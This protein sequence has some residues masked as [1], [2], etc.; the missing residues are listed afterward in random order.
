MGSTYGSY[1]Y[2]DYSGGYNNGYYGYNQQ[3]GSVLG[4]NTSMSMNNSQIGSAPEL[5]Q[6]SPTSKITDGI[7]KT[8]NDG[9]QSAKKSGGIG[10]FFKG[11][12]NGIK[13][14]FKSLLDPKTW[15]MIAACVALCVLVPGAG[16]VLM[17][18][19]IGMAG[20]Q[21]F[22]GAQSGDMEQVGEGAFN[23]GLSFLGGSSSV[24]AGT[25]AEAANFSR[26]GT[27]VAEAESSLAAAQKAGDV[28]AV[29]SAQK[30]VELARAQM[31]KADSSAMSAA[32]R[33]AHLKNPNVSSLKTAEDFKAA[34]ASTQDSLMEAKAGL[35]EAQAALAAAE[36]TKNAAEIARAQAKLT[37]AET[38]AKQAS[39]NVH[40]V[41]LAE[42]LQAT[43]DMGMMGRSWEHVKGTGT[44]TKDS[45]SMLFGK[46]MTS[47]D[48]RT[49]SYWSRTP[50]TPE[51]TATNAEAAA[52]KTGSK[53]N[54]LNWGKK[55]PAAVEAKD[56]KG[57]VS[58]SKSGTKT[59][60]T[61][62]PKPEE[63]TP[64]QQE[65]SSTITK[66]LADRQR[67]SFQAEEAAAK[68]RMVQ[69]EETYGKESKQYKTASRDATE[70]KAKAQR[71]AEISKGA[72]KEQIAARK[73]MAADEAALAAEKA[74]KAAEAKPGDTKLASEAERLQRIAATLQENAQKARGTYV[75]PSPTADTMAPGVWERIKG[76]IAPGIIGSQTA[77]TPLFGGM[78]GG[79]DGG[80]LFG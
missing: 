50:K 38:T 76:N 37:A 27:R 34:K 55:D 60:A 25:G 54:P 61:S 6:Q 48:G 46:Q 62:T 51:A 44:R 74:Q 12:F 17:A 5:T 30:T 22:K 2:G 41:Y 43:K 57:T 18:L 59:D 68:E 49:I 39:A 8:Y 75:K 36:K 23:L 64:R 28:K 65:A 21:I 33:E 66:N 78:L 45:F 24:K 29:E 79:G 31:A 19:G 67:A 3:G 11:I 56:P 63:L 10:D 40:D 42:R 47:A 52:T 69:A 73:Q 70:A 16:A 13:N 4:S 15:L 32:Q 7:T 53:W 71:Y 72:Q 35:D 20:M 80:G 26:A 1:G 9:L 14:L 58:S 77:I